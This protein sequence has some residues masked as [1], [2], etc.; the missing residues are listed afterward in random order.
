VSGQPPR[1][2]AGVYDTGTP[3]PARIYDYLLGG[4]DHF[5]AD[6]AAA[7]ELL[8]LVP[9]ARAGAREN[10]AFL[11]RAVRYLAGEA[12]I[13]Q[14]L[15]I[16]TGMP[17][18]GNVHQVAHAV[19]PDARVVYV[20]ND[21]VVHV[22]ADAL[23]AAPTTAAI[24]ADLRQPYRITQHPKTRKLLDLT[25][26]VAVLLVA[27]L[28]FVTDADDPAEVVACL[29]DA[30]PPGSYLV[31]SHA[32]GDFR[33]EVAG[34]VTEVYERASAPLVLR[35]RAQVAA[36]FHGLELLPPG[37][38]QPA[39]WRPDHGTREGVGGF[40]AGVGRK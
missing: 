14:F 36:L 4:K 7:E 34:K 8:A 2:A 33:P 31:V 23:L 12:G 27:V 3:N 26:P 28:H 17:T 24:L 38:V 21:P 25:R 37:L 10:R 40:W 6:R 29:R 9:E 13:R 5:P 15:D 39:A 32:T 35:S 18:Q 20:D 19:A 30:V 11:G 1:P 22:H 16:G